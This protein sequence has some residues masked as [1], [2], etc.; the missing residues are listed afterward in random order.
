MIVPPS[1]GRSL[2]PKI[3][4]DGEAEEKDK[5]LWNSGRLHRAPPEI[6]RVVVAA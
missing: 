4:N 3:E 2:H 5:K 6:G 1:T